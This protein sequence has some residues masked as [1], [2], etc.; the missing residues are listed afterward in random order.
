[1][2]CEGKTELVVPLTSRQIFDIEVDLF[3]LDEKHLSKDR[4]ALCDARRT[5]CVE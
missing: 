5:K 4:P 3:L 1:V 2:S